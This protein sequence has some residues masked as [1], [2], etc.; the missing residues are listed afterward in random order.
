MARKKKIPE[1][2][3]I[4]APVEEQAITKTLE[5]NFMPY[6]MSIII[7][8]AIPEIDG[9]K[10]AHRKLLYTMYKMGLLGG[11]FTKSANVVG[12][13]MK[14]NPHGDA[15]IYETMVRLTRG[16][17]ALLHP[18]VESQGNFG[19]VYSR[20]MAYA[21]PRYTEVRLE[22]ICAELFGDIN[23]NT[24]KFVDNY[25]GEL[26][27][28]T[29][30]PAAYPSILVNPNQGIAAGMASNICSFNLRE[31][32][33]ATIAF[34]KD[35]N[36][37][38]IDIMPAPDFSLGASIIYDREEMKKIY[39]TGR[40]SFKLRAKYTYDR[41][42]NCIDITEIPYTTTCEAIIGKI[43]E[44]L[45][46]NKL[47]EISDA[48]D[49]TDL[50]GFKLTI[51]LKRGTD[52]DELMLK[53]YKLT[54]LEDSFACNFNILIN[55]VPRVMGIR[56]ILGE[57]VKFRMEC[58]R[59]GIKFDIEQKS[60]RLHLLMGLKKILLDIDKAISIIRHTELDSEVIPNLMS[61]FGI[62]EVQ[63]EYISEIRL[64]NLNKEYILKNVDAIDRLTEEIAELNKTLSSDRLI[65]SRIAKQLRDI[66][67]KYGQD[68]KT[69]IIESTGLTE[70]KEEEHI[71]DYPLTI[72][73]T[74]G[75]YL[76]KVTAASLRSTTSEHKLK[77]DDEI[78]VTA[79]TTNKSELLFF[80]DMCNV[81]KIKTYDMPE[82][83]VTALGEYLPGILGL[84]ENEKIVYTVVT[85]DFEGLMLFTFENGKMAKVAL[86][87]Y[88]T[89]TNRKK[90]IG[91]YSAKSPIRDIKF[92][93]ED[94]DIAVV[95]D[96]GRILCLNTELIPLKSTKS[97]QGVQVIKQPKNGARPV[98]VKEADSCGIDGI[99]A[100]RI[101][102]I[103]AAAKSPKHEN[104]QLSLLP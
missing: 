5:T 27:E 18:L 91:A 23:K 102:S 79:E 41:E 73:F 65:K 99:S 74:R 89:K 31:V 24:V 53:L 3:I 81:Y 67:K 50:N 95:T 61:G 43:M 71:E 85:K 83:K 80:S 13:T 82:C 44:L 88:E 77:E 1:P 12:S 59:N 9:L 55:A 97:T 45:K 69:E 8:R 28:P 66:A 10:P 22:P 39:E 60:K 57:W 46:A 38:L 103:P 86:K 6:A 40:G 96:N 62:D 87:N 48:R 51:D 49:E 47:R 37:E 7:S 11:K 2:E 58:I 101:R 20:D 30:L 4:P 29:L 84:E 78:I 70:Y 92:L 52:P 68:R 93:K 42:N 26:K 56:E 35:K 34:M 72:F 21:A 64:R 16:N 14:L 33:E 75:Q 94:T 15:A 76:K 90:L 54:P 98:S 32:C 25:D 36:A 104:I 100:Y 17:E 63:A 19:K